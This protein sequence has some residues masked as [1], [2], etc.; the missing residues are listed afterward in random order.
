MRPPPPVKFSK[1]LKPEELSLHLPAPTRSESLRP[2]YTF[3]VHWLPPNLLRYSRRV[4]S[5][6]GDLDS[7]T[8]GWRSS[9]NQPWTSIHLAEGLTLFSMQLCE[10]PRGEVLPIEHV[11]P[12][13]AAFG[14]IASGAEV[15][16]AQT[17]VSLVRSRLSCDALMAL[18]GTDDDDGISAMSRSLQQIV[19]NDSD[20]LRQFWLIRPRNRLH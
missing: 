18:R 6:R 7:W 3:P 12:R 4:Y 5:R 10:M 13:E 1:Y 14:F 20:M 19:V 16:D 11:V 15:K 9:A 8:E 17:L 2:L